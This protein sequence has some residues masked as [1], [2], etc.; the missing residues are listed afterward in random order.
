MP[1]E[2]KIH[3]LHCGYIRL[4]KSMPNAGELKLSNSLRHVLA[5][6]SKRVTLPVCAYLIEHPVHGKILVDTGWCRDISPEGVYD[7]RALKKLMPGYLADFYRPYL[8]KG[9][10]IHEQLEKM[11]IRPEDLDCVVITHLDPDHVSGVKHLQGAKRIVV[12]EFEYFFS[13]RYVFR[14]HQPW[15]M[16]MQYP[17]ERIFY[18]A[19]PRDRYWNFGKPI[20]LNHWTI[21]LFGDDSISI[22]NVPGHTEGIGAVIVNTDCGF[23]PQDFVL[24]TS[25]AAFSR[26]SW[27]DMSIS[28]LGYSK[29]SMLRSLDWIKSMSELPGC[30]AVFASHDPDVQPRTVTLQMKR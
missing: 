22:V 6:D 17:M 12:A 20:N 29:T 15:K 18:R 3:I 2:I 28:G 1:K 13:C 4:E 24:L 21:D 5:G 8:P 26:Q 30:K 25:D 23:L 14:A 27:E 7:R 10:A 19:T 11:G 16:F 9:M